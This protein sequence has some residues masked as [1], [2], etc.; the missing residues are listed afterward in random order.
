MMKWRIAFARA[1]SSSATLT[2]SGKTPSANSLTIVCA[3]MSP[4][5]WIANP[6]DHARICCFSA[7]EYG[8]SSRWAS[9]ALSNTWP[10]H[11]PVE[12]G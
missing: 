9:Q 12:S 2:K 10:I 3:H 8:E 6:Y 4:A 11:T 1:R 5:A 7:A